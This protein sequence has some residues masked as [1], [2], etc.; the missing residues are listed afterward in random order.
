[1]HALKPLPSPCLGTTSCILVLIQRANSPMVKNHRTV[2]DQAP[3]WE[4]LKHISGKCLV[5]ATLLLMLKTLLSTLF[6]FVQ[7]MVRSWSR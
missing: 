7:V 5:K 1:M 6:I 4:A 3:A 2:P